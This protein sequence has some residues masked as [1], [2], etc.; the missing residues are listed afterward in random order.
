MSWYGD[1]VWLKDVLAQWIPA[2]KLC[3]LPGWQDTG[4]GDFEDIWGVIIHH[5]GNAR[6]TAQ[7]I[8]VGRPDLD[9]PLSN[10]HIAPDGVVT[11]VAQGVCWHAGEGSYI[12]LPTDNANFHTIGIECAWPSNTLIRPETEWLERWP[13]AQIIS[14]RDSVAG[15]LKKLG[16]GANRVIGHKEWAGRAQGKWDPGNINMDWFRGEVAKAMRGDFKVAKPKDE[17]IPVKR[18]PED[19]TDRE[20]LE[21]IWRKLSK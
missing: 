17:T 12:G 10:L 19:A 9:G 13:D 11:I 4:H 18:W 6:E 3:E 5:T 8:Q 16:V 1:P 14:M 15:I 20:L 2:D 21:D 7:S